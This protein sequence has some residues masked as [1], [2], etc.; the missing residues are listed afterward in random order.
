MQAVTDQTHLPLA[1]AEARGTYA[2]AIKLYAD[3]SPELA[4]KDYY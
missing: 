3:L 2:T 4:E 1:V